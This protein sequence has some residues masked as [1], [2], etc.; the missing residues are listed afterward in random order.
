MG[1][2]R[3]GLLQKQRQP[4][5]ESKRCARVPDVRD[6][7]QTEDRRM[8]VSRGARCRRTISAATPITVAWPGKV[9]SGVTKC[10]TDVTVGGGMWEALGISIRKQWKVRLH[11]CPTLRS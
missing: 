11:M 2:N 6:L 4:S 9:G 3:K 5:P 10:A 8:H 1:R 7:R